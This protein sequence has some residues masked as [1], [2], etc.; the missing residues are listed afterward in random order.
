MKIFEALSAAAGLL[1]QH[2]VGNSRQDAESLLSHAMEKNRSYLIA[3]NRE[4]MEPGQWADFVSLVTERSQ[5]KPLQYIL[6]IQEFLGMEF[7]VT[8]EVLIPRPETELLV[9]AARGLFSS[10]Q[11]PR[12]VD[13]GTGSGCI[14]VSL[15]V[16]IPSARVCAVDLSE[17]ALDVARRNAAKHHVL[18]R[19][20]FLHG[21][22][23]AL[24]QRELGEEALDGIV[25]NPPYIS[26]KD[27]PG[28][29]KE[30]RGWEPLLALAGGARGLAIYER[31]IPQALRYLKP[32]SHLLMEIGCNMK[33]DVLNLIGGGWD[34]VQV[35]ADHNQ[36]PRVVIARKA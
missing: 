7:E 5:G 12:I 31:L 18:H 14:A 23:L 19:L 13:V 4:N 28:L 33:E 16:L 11:Y 22:L 21:D 32:R 27:F 35:K 6:G 3:H 1:E 17:A 2:G 25:S 15:A 36:I 29:Q 8:P 34:Q 9:E 26:E 20:E 24:T 30:V 10:M